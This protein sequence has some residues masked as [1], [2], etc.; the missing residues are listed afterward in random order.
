MAITEKTRKILW[1]RSGNRCALCRRLLVMP[2]TT[3][4]DAAVISDEC[5]IVSA[6]QNGPRG[7]KK[8][9][10]DEY[11]KP[12]N[13]LLLCKVHHKQ[14][15]DQ[16]NT[17]TIEHLTTTKAKHEKWVCDSLA[18][19][20]EKQ[21]CP[22][23]FLTRITTGKELMSMNSGCCAYLFDHDEPENQTEMV[24]IS[25]FQQNAQDYCEIWD[26]IEAGGRVEAQFE[27]TKQ[28]TELE[29]LGFW[30][31]SMRQDRKINVMGQSETWPVFVMTV[32]RETNPGVTPVG[33]LASIQ[34]QA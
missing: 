20:T 30:I 2:E 24:A 15:D 17:F 12:A 16:E 33:E 14:V 28:I 29:K 34:K 27:I 19:K 25:A 5:H 1:A 10:Q 6:K 8:L 7:S 23:E 4:D 18:P 32:V 22:V 21:Q 11:D 3:M 13:L 26:E 9:P 31:F